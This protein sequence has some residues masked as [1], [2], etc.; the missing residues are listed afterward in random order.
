MQHK[1]I[2]APGPWGLP[3]K[4]KILPQYLKEAGYM[5]RAIG[6]W[7]L[8]FSRKEYTPIYRGFDSHYGYWNGYHDYFDHT[9]LATVSRI[10]YDLL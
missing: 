2:L 5:T 7:H 6:K 10:D 8:G 4:E 1:V 9:M 3:L